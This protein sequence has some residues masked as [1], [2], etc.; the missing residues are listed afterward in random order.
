MM[1][2]LAYANRLFVILVIG[3]RYSA[4]GSFVNTPLRLTAEVIVHTRQHEDNL[5]TDIHCFICQS[6]EVAS[7]SG[8]NMTN[9]KPCPIPVTR[10]GGT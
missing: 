3:V 1:L 7:F 2:I 4:N 10:T 9:N 8:L 5:V 6:Y